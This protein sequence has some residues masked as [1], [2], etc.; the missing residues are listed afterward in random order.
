MK[1]IGNLKKQDKKNV[2]EEK[3][4]QAEKKAGKV[5]LD[6]DLLSAVSGGSVVVEIQKL[7]EFGK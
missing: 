1:L 3:D 5:S 2:K 4:L 6:D 7:K